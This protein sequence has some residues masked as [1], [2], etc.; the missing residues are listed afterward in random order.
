VNISENTDP[1]SMELNFLDLMQQFAQKKFL[2]LNLS[3]VSE[4]R[5]DIRN[6]LGFRHLEEQSIPAYSRKD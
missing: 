1:I 6:T 2:R 3:K 5:C 4:F